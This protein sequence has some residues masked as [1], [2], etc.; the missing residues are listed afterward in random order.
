MVPICTAAVVDL[1]ANLIYFP[2]GM[3]KSVGEKSFAKQKKFRKDS[4]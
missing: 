1:V 3:K 2:E 4:I